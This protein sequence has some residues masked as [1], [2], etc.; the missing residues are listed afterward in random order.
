M[1]S[2]SRPDGIQMTTTT[3]TIA[4][5]IE[6]SF[7]ALLDAAAASGARLTWGRTRLTGRHWVALRSLDGRVRRRRARTRAQAAFRL[8]RVIEPGAWA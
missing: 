7:D 8:L 1:R 5:G 6:S 2:H 4:A 3:P